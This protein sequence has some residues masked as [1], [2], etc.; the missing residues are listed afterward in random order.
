MP[1]APTTAI[2]CP[3]LSAR[4]QRAVD[5]AAAARTILEAEGSG[6][7]TMRRVAES[8]GI[9]A[10]SLYK[11]FPD[12][13]ALEAALIEDA[14]AEMGAVLHA[15]LARPGRH[16]PVA[17]LLAAYRTEALAHPNLY[18][19]ATAGQL[20]R[21]E[22]ARRP[23]SVGGRALLPRHGRGAPRAGA[24]VLRARHGDPRDR[25]PVP[26]QL[27]PRQ[28]LASGSRRVQPPA[29]DG[30]R[31]GIRPRSHGLIRSTGRSG[32]NATPVSG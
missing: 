26:R 31:R 9:K 12:K 4:T 27:G 21:G 7:V 6:A 16:A 25:R 23:R 8:L 24:V 29:I 17:A 13:G 5:V 22:P 14:L 19:L 15:A 18:R 1:V 32:T 2:E 20:P 11:H 3:I 30:A 10:P 28:H